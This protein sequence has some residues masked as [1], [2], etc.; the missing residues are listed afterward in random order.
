MQK[1][2]AETVG[3]QALGWLA[4]QDDLLEMFLGASGANVN[5]LKLMAQNPEFLGSVLD[6]ILMADEHV[7]GFCDATGLPYELPMKARQF[8]PGGEAFNWT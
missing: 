3:I 4:G 5:D 6:F 8:L 7:A 2:Q 1:E